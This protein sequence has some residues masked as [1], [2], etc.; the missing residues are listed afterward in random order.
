M[1]KETLTGKTVIVCMPLL[2]NITTATKILSMSRSKIYK[3]LSNG[4]FGPE[5]IKVGKRSL[6]RYKELEQWVDAGLPS[7][8][9]WQ[10]TKC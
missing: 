10:K 8:G 1:S 7:K 9:K 2:V 6:F 5:L 3:M 4:S